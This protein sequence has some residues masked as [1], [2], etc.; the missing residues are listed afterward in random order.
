MAYKLQSDIFLGRATDIVDNIDGT[1]LNRICGIF[2]S[3][4]QKQ[5]T[6]L[7]PGTKLERKWMF[8]KDNFTFQNVIFLSNLETSPFLP[9][10]ALAMVQQ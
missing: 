8:L 7:K 10:L 1:S 4:T 3:R 2:T 6:F 5:V 9:D